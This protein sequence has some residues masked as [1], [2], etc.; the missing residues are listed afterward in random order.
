MNESKKKKVTQTTN[1]KIS[2]EKVRHLRRCSLNIN[3]KTKKRPLRRFTIWWEKTAVE[4]FFE[5]V[6]FVL[7]N[8]ALLDII[9][10]LAGVTIIISLITW[11]IG[12]Q[13]RWEDEIF[14]TWQVVNHASEDKSGVKRLALERLLR[15]RFS[16]NGLDLEKI[17][18]QEVNLQQADLLET[19]LQQADL[20]G[21]NLQ[22]AELL[23]AN[24]QQADLLR[25][26][27]QQAIIL[28]A[29]L[30]EVKL[31]GANLQQA[32]LWETNLQQADLREANLQQAELLGADLQQADLRGTNFQQAE[33]L[34]VNLQQADLL[35]ANLQQAVL[36]NTKELTFK[37][38]KSTCFWEK[39]IYKRKW[40]N[41]EKTYI[42]TEPDNTNFIKKL[43]QDKSSEPEKPIDCS[44][45]KR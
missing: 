36:F 5:D 39:A 3:D 19:N 45:W 26:N 27:L 13:E 8:A 4:K 22:Q 14:S 40:N 11:L 25:A 10:L 2:A 24:L 44:G 33:L 7:K 12:R 1:R 9:N 6:V 21:A 41:N 30:Q 28:D 43:K 31:L 34:G 37:Q 20:R 32:K 17:N 18:L 23:G 42:T 16:L 15:N 29:N 38:I 35:G